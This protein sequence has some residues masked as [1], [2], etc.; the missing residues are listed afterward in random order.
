MMKALNKYY[1]GANEFQG[2]IKIGSA[3]EYSAS[4]K[5]FSHRLRSSIK[6]SYEAYHGSLE[7][8]RLTPD[9]EQSIYNE[10]ESHFEKVPAMR[11]GRK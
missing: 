8:I 4:A 7:G 11:T 3:E 1:P 6:E 10:I 9:N 2:E 5:M